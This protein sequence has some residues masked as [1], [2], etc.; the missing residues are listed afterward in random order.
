MV[1]AK[2]ADLN[3]N[4]LDYLENLL[5]RELVL[6]VQYESSINQNELLVLQKIISAVQSQK[7]LTTIDK[8]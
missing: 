4:D 3:E 7:H 5:N 8:W 2:F 1:S 6:R